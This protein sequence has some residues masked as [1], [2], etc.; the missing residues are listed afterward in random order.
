MEDFYEVLGV[1]IYASK[2]EIRRA[3]YESAE[4]CESGECES[5]K[6]E[7]MQALLQ[8]Y[9]VLGNPTCRATYDRLMGYT[10]TAEES[11]NIFVKIGALIAIV[12]LVLPKLG[13]IFMKLQIFRNVFGWIWEN[14]GLRWLFEHY[15]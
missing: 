11:G 5:E 10:R 3:F 6:E 13:V 1:D 15:S 9:D 7:R 4:E 8:A 12:V 2:K 14:C